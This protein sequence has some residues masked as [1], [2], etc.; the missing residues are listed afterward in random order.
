MSQKAIIAVK[1]THLLA[2]QIILFTQGDLMDCSHREVLFPRAV[3]KFNFSIL[4]LA[5]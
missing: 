5:T 3:F 1:L 2:H 4:E